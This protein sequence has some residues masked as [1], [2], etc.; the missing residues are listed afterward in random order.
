MKG[1]RRCKVSREPGSQYC[2]FHEPGRKDIKR[3]K[4]RF[5]KQI[6]EAGS[7][8]ERNPRYDFTG[9]VFPMGI[10]ATAGDRKTSADVILPQKIVGDLVCAETV[11]KG[12]VNFANAK[13]KGDVI[14]S[15]ATIEGD[16]CFNDAA[17]GK[18]DDCVNA[19]IK[20]GK[21]DFSDATIRGNANFVHA[22]IGGWAWFLNATIKGSA[23]FGIARIKGGVIFHSA[24]IEGTAYFQDATIEK[25]SDF[26]HFQANWLY[27][28][29]GR[30]TILP[31]VRKRRGI[32]L[33]DA[34]TAESFW[35]FAR[36]TFQKEGRR[37]EADAAYY[38]ERL[39]RMSPRKIPLESDWRKWA[40]RG[41]KRLGIFLIRWLPD[42]LFLRWPT[43]YGASLL[44]LL[45]AWGI[46]IGG[47]AGL[48]HV[49]TMGDNMLFDVSSPGLGFSFTFGRALYFS[50]ITFTTLGYGDIRPAPGLGSALTATEAVLGGIMMALTVL[51]I[52]RK[53]MR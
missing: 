38:F 9:Y 47:F 8:E 3:F 5:Y 19:K 26:S 18:E 24:T 35:L 10:R 29:D 14:F 34:G 6:D 1:L 32:D 41:M 37:N 44:R 53:F 39:S 11:I 45:A 30:P 13:I 12:D 51:V 22:T 4:E 27:L 31:L 36:L 50:I 42:S 21:A 33:G 43:A 7:E 40:Y 16:A 25:G 49:L 52:G 28:G 2:I 15:S 17:I 46:I 20:K 48:Y 23:N